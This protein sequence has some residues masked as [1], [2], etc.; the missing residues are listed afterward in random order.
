MR[1]L[2]VFTSLVLFAGCAY[3]TPPVHSPASIPAIA[4]RSLRVESA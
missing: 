2:L 1:F 3:R 4:Q